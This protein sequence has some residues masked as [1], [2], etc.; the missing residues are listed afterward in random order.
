MEALSRRTVSNFRFGSEAFLTAGVSD[1]EE[2][3]VRAVV[4]MDEG[5]KSF[6]VFGWV[7]RRRLQCSNT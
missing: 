2:D 5:C 4:G 1:V 3:E 6:S 7:L